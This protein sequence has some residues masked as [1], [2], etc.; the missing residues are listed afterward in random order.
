MKMNKKEK[1]KKSMKRRRSRRCLPASPRVTKGEWNSCSSSKTTH[2]WPPIQ[3][4]FRVS[5]RKFLFQMIAYAY[6]TNW[7]HVMYG[8]L[9]VRCWTVNRQFLNKF[10]NSKPIISGHRFCFSGNAR[11]SPEICICCHSSHR[12]HDDMTTPRL[13]GC[14]RKSRWSFEAKKSQLTAWP[15][16]N[17][18][19]KAR[20]MMGSLVFV[21]N[22]L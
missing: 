12:E 6:D 7:G 8:L 3:G 14:L 2:D 4:T 20:R 19:S 9:I 1:K 18:Q 5:K 22:W 16:E 15:P 17:Y 21:S 13:A 10:Q 11:D